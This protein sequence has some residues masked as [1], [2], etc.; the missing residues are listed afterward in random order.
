MIFV[1]LILDNF[2]NNYFPPLFIEQKQYRERI[3]T[4]IGM[5]KRVPKVVKK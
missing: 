4:H 2:Y 1:Q 5:R 3:K